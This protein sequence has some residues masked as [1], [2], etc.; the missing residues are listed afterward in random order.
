MHTQLINI[1]PQTA[2][3]LLASNLGNRRPKPA[4]LAYWEGVLKSGSYIPTHQGLALQ[5][6]DLENPIRV[7]DGQHR[8]LAVQIT[9]VTAPFNVTFG[10]PVASFGTIDCGS[11][12]SLIDRTGIHSKEL[13]VVSF[14][15]NNKA[16]RLRAKPTALEVSELHAKLRRY[17][18]FRSFRS[19]V[20]NL[21][22]SAI[23]TAFVL[24]YMKTGE[25]GLYHKY[26][27]GDFQSLPPALSSLYRRA[28]L[29]TLGGGRDGQ[30]RAFACAWA[31]L[32]KQH[33]KTVR[34]PEDFREYSQNTIS[35][36]I[37]NL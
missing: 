33:L 14:I 18:E 4:N 37:K 16:N 26:V 5:G 25:E 27:T 3:H 32:N 1:T 35:T 15:L 24:H 23:R 28:S 29:N 9:G 17:M 19:G 2:S 8:L 21:T 10:A 13:Q 11:P 36:L 22:V 7:I 30:A 31:C 34:I 20:R 6:N 12:R